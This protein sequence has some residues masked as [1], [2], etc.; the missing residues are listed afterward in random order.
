MRRK[1]LYCVLLLGLSVNCFGCGKDPL[2][3]DMINKID[4][5]GE[6]TIEDQ[7]QI[8]SLEET[9]SQMTEKQKNQVTN[10][11][12]LKNARE[13]LD[14]LKEE[15]AE[16]EQ[17]EKEVYFEKMRPYYSNV[18]NMIKRLK[19][20]L[21]NP[22]SLQIKDIIY[23]ASKKSDGLQS[24]DIAFTAQNNLGADIDDVATWTVGTS[25]VFFQSEES[26]VDYDMDVRVVSGESTGYESD[27]GVI[28]NQ[29]DGNAIM[30]RIDLQ[31]Y[32]AQGYSLK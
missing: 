13:K 21:K 26:W 8:E 4:A 16:K 27:D 32:E 5:L 6:I 1:L 14:G 28:Y 11:I 23:I 25:S 12:D 17:E 24:C 18:D 2:A 30:F 10:Y 22:S 29:V 20:D 31:D 15:A 7:T 9:Y 19:K 3:Q